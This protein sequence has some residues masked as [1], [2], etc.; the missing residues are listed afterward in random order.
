MKYQNFRAYNGLVNAATAAVRNLREKPSSCCG[1]ERAV[2]G[3]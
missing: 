1:L 3:R 2:G